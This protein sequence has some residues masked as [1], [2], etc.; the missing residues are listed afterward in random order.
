MITEISF[1]Q[2]VNIQFMQ[3]TWLE[4]LGTISGFLCVYLA[5][6]QH[7]LNWPLAIISITSYL[8]LFYEYKLYGDSALQI[9]FLA[10]SIYGWRFWIKRKASVEVP[11]SAL[12]RK[13][14][15]IAV[16]SIL[17]LSGLTGVILD[18]K[19]DS[20]VPYADAFCTS[21]SLVAQFLLT[22]KILQNWTLWIIVDICYIP[23]YLHKELYLTAMLYALFLILA[24]M[25]F[26]DWKKTYLKSKAILL[27]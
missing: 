17:F 12:T 24:V 21:V 23:L 13:E 8:F 22:R 16:L 15:I 18:L 19:T 27:T 6:K 10:T 1:W 3:T 25:G 5:A 2:Q 11:V 7:I 4:W 20:D 26:A 14:T 9:Y